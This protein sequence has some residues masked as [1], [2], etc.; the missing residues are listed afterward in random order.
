MG[1]RIRRIKFVDCLM[2]GRITFWAFGTMGLVTFCAS[3]H[4]ICSDP[5][6]VD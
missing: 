1:F 2:R 5:D 6:L 3:D 4:F